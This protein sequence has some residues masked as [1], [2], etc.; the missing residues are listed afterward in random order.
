MVWVPGFGGVS[1][2][3]SAGVGMQSNT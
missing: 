3:V 2:L 1:E